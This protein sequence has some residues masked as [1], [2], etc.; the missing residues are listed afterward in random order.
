MAE[1]FQFLRLIQIL[2]QHYQ[3]FIRFLEFVYE[4]HLHLGLNQS[5]DHLQSE[6]PYKVESFQFLHLNQSLHLHL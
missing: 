1:S 6:H 4:V 5:L 2:N 3:R